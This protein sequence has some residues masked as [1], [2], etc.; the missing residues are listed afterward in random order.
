M[1]GS[2]LDKRREENVCNRIL[3]YTYTFCELP[4]KNNT[5]ISN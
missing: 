3:K 4:M 5:V 1:E 2:Q